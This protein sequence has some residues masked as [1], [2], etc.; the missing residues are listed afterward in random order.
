MPKLPLF[1]GIIVRPSGGRGHVPAPTLIEGTSV[2]TARGNLKPR[3][4]AEV[5][6]AAIGAATAYPFKIDVSQQLRL[7]GATPP[8]SIN[9]VGVEE[10]TI[11]SE[12][13]PWDPDDPFLTMDEHGVVTYAPKGTY[14]R[15]TLRL[16]V[17][18]ADK[19]NPSTA[20]GQAAGEV[21][22]GEV[23]EDDGRRGAI[24]GVPVAEGDILDFIVQFHNN[25]VGDGFGESLFWQNQGMEPTCALAACA[26]VLASLAI[27]DENGEF[28][29][30]WKLLQQALTLTFPEHPFDP[31]LPEEFRVP[32]IPLYRAHRTERVL[33]EPNRPAIPQALLDQDVP[34]EY[35]EILTNGDVMQTREYFDRVTQTAELTPEAYA[36]LYELLNY[37]ESDD[38]D[39]EF[40]ERPRNVSNNAA[41]EGDSW[42]AIHIMLNANGVKTR[43]GSGAEVSTIIQ[44]LLAGNKVIVGVDANELAER[45]ELMKAQS[46]SD[47][48]ALLNIGEDLNTLA[49]HAIWLTEIDNSDP[50]NP[51]V[52]I[53]DSARGGGIEMPLDQFLAAWEDADYMYV[54][55]GESPLPPEIAA[56]GAEIQRMF[57]ETLSQAK[58][59]D[60]H[61]DR[62]ARVHT[63]VTLAQWV[64]DPDNTSFGDLVREVFPESEALALEYLENLEANRE[65]ILEMHNFDPD[66]LENLVKDLNKE[67][68]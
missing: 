40:A 6:N 34:D 50:N 60:F 30:Y 51:T 20:F 49:N 37:R 39:G 67:G 21:Y 56:Q 1:E 43:T 29:D 8:Y 19:D 5:K 47:R 58:F 11:S 48:L 62:L 23:E 26:G 4:D 57:A 24:G 61:I 46:Q 54:A 63:T 45:P 12:Q 35:F 59:S 13:R 41:N 36:Y 32:P 42:V 14:V 25:V 52:T 64:A 55:T 68:E 2:N 9:L 15:N 38:Y 53:N 66:L 16:Q 33:D 28:I 22:R 44:E 10:L 3:L 17:E 7:K 18:L 31:N 65:E 27:I